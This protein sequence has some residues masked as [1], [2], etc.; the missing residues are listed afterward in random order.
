M[1]R[2]PKGTPNQHTKVKVGHVTH[3]RIAGGT[4][5]CEGPNFAD[6]RESSDV[7]RVT[8][9]NCKDAATAEKGR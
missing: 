8:C 5:A 2:T 4:I 3:L 7:A 1:N 6:D 9:G